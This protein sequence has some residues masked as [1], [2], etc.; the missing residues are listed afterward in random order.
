LRARLAAE[1]EKIRRYQ[2]NGE[3][4]WTI[5]TFDGPSDT[6]I[7]PARPE[8]RAHL[9]AEREKIRRWQEQQEQQ[10]PPEP[11]ADKHAD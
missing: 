9:E 2:G 1:R 8:L 5:V 11:D 6:T 7:R 4:L 3:D 10:K